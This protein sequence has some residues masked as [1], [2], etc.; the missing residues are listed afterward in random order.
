M[1]IAPDLAI[2]VTALGQFSAGTGWMALVDLEGDAIAMCQYVSMWLVV[3]WY[4]YPSE[5]Y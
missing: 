2:S 4:T 5:K 3:Y 1:P